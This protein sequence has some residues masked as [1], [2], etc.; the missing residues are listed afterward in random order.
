MPTIGDEIMKAFE[1]AEEFENRIVAF[2]D[3]MGMKNRLASA[4]RPEDFRKYA[5]I[6]NMFAKQPFAEG[7]LHVTMFSDCMYI[8]TER[9]YIDLIINLLANFSFTLL[10]NNT[11]EII[12][13][14]DGSHHTINHFDCFKL[15]GGITYGN[16]FILDEEAKR[17]CITLNSN[18]L[19]GKA[20]MDAYELES[21]KAVYPRIIVDDC[22]LSLMEEMGKTPEQYFL[23]QENGQYYL[24][25]LDYMCQGRRNGSRALYSIEHWIGFVEDEIK[26]ALAK[27]NAK[28][29][30]QLLWYKEYLQKHVAT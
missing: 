15:R 26:S 29:V 19:L 25:F 20:V 1:D 27:K 12:V 23:V 6:M 10:N 24:D 28:L 21:K 9:K 22:F 4:T 2:I 13:H 5:T 16:V 18:I 8:I 30:G 17:R 3:V 11:P 14:G 7:K